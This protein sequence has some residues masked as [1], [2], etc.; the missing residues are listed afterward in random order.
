VKAKSHLRVVLYLLLLVLAVLLLLSLFWE[1]YLEDLLVPYI[2]EYY[3]P[4]PLY[5]R[6]EFVI[7]AV[8]FSALA[9]IIPT[10]VAFR[11]IKDA[12]QAREALSSA[13]DKLEDRVQE[14]TREL[15][16]TN[17][18][19]ER[20]IAEQA[21]TENAL[22]KSEKELRLLSTQLLKAQENERRRIA[23]DLHDNVSQTLAAMKFRIEHALNESVDSRPSPDEMSRILVPVVQETIDEVRNMYMRLRPSILDDLGLAATLT[24]LRRD[25]QGAHPDIDTRID[26]NIAESEIADDLKIVIYRVVQEALA[27]VALHSKAD[28]VRVSLDRNNNTVELTVQ[29]NGTGFSLEDVMSV[30]DSLRGMGLSGMRE[31]IELVGGKLAVFGGEGEGATICAS[32]PIRQQQS[33]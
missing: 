3:H 7:T 17:K 33:A 29:D 22:R 6:L 1:F 15:T 16:E 23:L 19:L 28:Q 9:L 31:R 12:D 8:G 14:R 21:E 32:I 5:E 25:Y 18:K 27:N 30:D 4:E 24:W 11:N 20:A 2:Y 26:V 10:M 13:Y